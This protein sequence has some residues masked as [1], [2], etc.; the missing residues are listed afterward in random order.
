MP[1]RPT[2][3]QLEYIVAVDDLR[4][5]GRAAR[6][7][8]V[9]QPTL[10]VQVGL[11]EEALGTALFE[12]S[13]SG[14]TPTPAGHAFA[15]GARLVLAGTDD[16]VAAAKR[17]TGMLG[18]VM[19]LGAAASFGPYF[20]PGLLSTIHAQYPDLKLYIHEDRPSLL[21]AAVMEGS[22]DCGLGPAPERPELAFHAVGTEQLL[23][24]VAADHPLAGRTS[25]TIPELRHERLLALGS[26]HRLL[27]NVRHLATASGAE[28]IDDYEGSSLDAIR[29]MVSIGMG[30]SV[31]PQLYAR[32]EMEGAADIRL[33]SIAGWDERRHVGLYWRRGTARATHYEVLAAQSVVVAR[34]LGIASART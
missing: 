25:V 2:L 11:V 13:S 34:R 33:L 31:F 9:S 28:L 24:A 8:H 17:D 29:Q 30:C 20:L 23:L 7:C 10:S 21:E 16:I 26:G 12:R 18:G 14:A 27:E 5:F 22:L 15:R 32:A 3:R 1:Y 6:R 4:H 19:R